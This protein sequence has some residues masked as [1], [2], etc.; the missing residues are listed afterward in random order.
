MA[1]DIRPFDGKACAVGNNTHSAPD[2]RVPAF[3]ERLY[4]RVAA[5]DRQ[6][7]SQ[8][9]SSISPRSLAR[10]KKFIRRSPAWYEPV[11]QGRAVRLWRANRETPLP[12]WM[13]VEGYER[14]VPPRA[15]KNYSADRKKSSQN[16]GQK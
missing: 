10:Q 11:A 6:E 7:N 15:S 8:T 13:I 2:E 14:I 16:Y 12:A 3:M 9:R 1:F 5:Y 4:A